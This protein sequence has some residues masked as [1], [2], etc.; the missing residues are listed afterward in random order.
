ME[1]IGGTNYDL[2]FKRIDPIMG[3]GVF[4]N[5]KINAGSVVETCY[6]LPCNPSDPYYSNYIFSI[7]G[8]NEDLLSLGFGS[9]YNHSET[10]NIRWTIES[11]KDRTIK[12]I[13]IRDIKIGEELLHDYG[14]KW[15]GKRK[16]LKLI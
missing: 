6:C 9:I 8:S 12:F 11:I 4:T 1:Q 2:Y 5:S 16:E 10:P 14:K 3:F 15:W 13:A 7:K